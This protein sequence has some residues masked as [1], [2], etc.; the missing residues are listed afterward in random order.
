MLLKSHFDFDFDFNHEPKMLNNIAI[1]IPISIHSDLNFDS[2]FGH[3]LN[4][5]SM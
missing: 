1:L 4:V 3:E 2:D 5:L